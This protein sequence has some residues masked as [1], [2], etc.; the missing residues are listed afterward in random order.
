MFAKLLLIILTIIVTAAALMITRQRRIDA[1]HEMSGLHQRMVEQEAALWILRS[2]I[3]DRCR[4]ERVRE[5]L[6]RLGGE[7]EPIP[8]QPLRVHPAG[9][10]FATLPES[11][12]AHAQ[13]GR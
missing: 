12:V 1:M 4:P 8:N 11:E 13:A 7:W 6:E 10:R 2:R 9:G 5:A 3:A